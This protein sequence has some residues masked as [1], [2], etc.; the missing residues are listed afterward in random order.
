MRKSLSWSVLALSSVATA[1]GCA[2]GGGTSGGGGNASPVP[3]GFHVDASVAPNTPTIIGRGDVPLAVAAVVD[4]SGVQSDFVAD[5]ILLRPQ[6]TQELADFV[7]RYGATVVGDDHIPD[8]PG[9]PGTGSPATM[10]RVRLN[11]HETGTDSLDADA[12]AVGLGGEHAFSSPDAAKLTATLA[13]EA[14]AGRKVSLDFVSASHGIVHSSKESPVDAEP[15]A[16]R[17]AEYTGTF[18]GNTS[19][20]TVVGAWQLLEGIGYTQHSVPVAIIDGGFWLDDKGRPLWTNVGSDL[21]SDMLEY[22]FVNGVYTAG[23]ENPNHCTGGSSCPWHGNGTVGVAAGVLYNGFG[24]AGT[25]GQVAQPMLFRIGGSVFEELS[26]VKTAVAWGAK[27]VNMSFGASCDDVC[28]FGESFIDYVGIFDD[29]KKAGL[30][31]V[32]SA[33]NDGKDADS[34]S[35]RPCTVDSVICVGAL[36]TDDMSTAKYTEGRYYDTAGSYSNYGSSVAIFAPGY[37]R[38]MP[39]PDTADGTLAAHNATS[40]AAPYVSGVVAMMAAVDPSLTS[41]DARSILEKTAHTGSP[42]PKVAR[43]LDA[44]YA[45]L[46]A[47]GG[48]IA[49]DAYEPND[50]PSQA[51][52]L[53]RG[54]TYDMTFT[55]AWDKDYLRFSLADFGTASFAFENMHEGLGNVHFSILPEDGQSDPDL[56]T[57]GP[58]AL[59]Y[60]YESKLLAPGSY[61]VLVT[62]GPQ[63]YKVAFNAAETGLAPD[64]Y[65]VNDTLA[66][67]AYVAEGVHPVTLHTAADVDWYEFYV[68]G[69]DSDKKSYAY[70]VQSLDADVH[71]EI[72]DLSNHL[73][74]QCTGSICSASFDKTKNGTTFYAH[75]TGNTRTRYTIWNGVQADPSVFH[76]GL[77]QKL[78][79]LNPSDPLV[80]RELV[81]VDEWLVVEHAPSALGQGTSTVVLQGAGLHMDLVG[82]DGAAIS[83][84]VANTDATMPGETA[85]MSSVPVGGVALVHVTRTEGTESPV[86]G[87]RLVLPRLVYGV[88]AR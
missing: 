15:D 58:T 82:V 2:A 22:D 62:G 75:V 4:A 86:D 43:F 7:A 25:G 50:T 80:Q 69:V 20:A 41:D 6:D 17:W 27:V 85:D 26:A 81:A 66:Q 19:G 33:G 65:E 3:F 10:Y 64:A 54:N 76:A 60:E 59:G 52:E 35:V 1:V 44:H 38:T 68:S 47:N 74:S 9:K 49:K 46:E 21:T 30:V 13:H 57:Q 55:N 53:T 11:G 72:Y 12:T 87:S 83:S 77:T 71:F 79:W 31:L 5:E 16:F 45:V 61:R 23:G 37:V 14:A 42:D 29:A 32:A 24:A 63:P 18:P 8:L 36:A 28:K 34:Q 51:T 78:W 56:V 48:G 84:G 39:N 67:V 70:T 73:L 40:C 88:G